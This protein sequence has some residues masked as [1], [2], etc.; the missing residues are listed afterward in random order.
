MK[1]LQL[2]LYTSHLQQQYQFYK[3]M[4]ELEVSEFS[5]ENF[6]VHAGFSELMFQYSKN[7]TPYHIAFHISDKQE[8]KALKWVKKRVPILKNETEEIID[9]NAWNAKSIYFYDE[10]KNIL[11]FISRRN[12]SKPKSTL[13]SSESILGISE[14][15]I[16]TTDVKEKFRFL[17]AKFSLEKYD[18]DF[19]KFCA[20]G[21]DDGLLITINR[22]QKD[23]FP[24][25]DKA[26]A[27]EFCI[28]FTHESENYHLSFEDDQLKVIS[29]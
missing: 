14:V 19:E 16:G 18:G 22:T 7:A 15:G 2:Q 8:E 28:A 24:T 9:F 21:N 23:W 10:D 26:F 4:L 27:S 17:N 1:I 20:I 3:D 11:E 13:F 25:N 29:A 12:F 6:K 5:G